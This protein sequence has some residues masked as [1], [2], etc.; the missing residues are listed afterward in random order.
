MDPDSPTK[1]Q[2]SAF[3][4]IVKSAQKEAEKNTSKEIVIVEET[5]KTTFDEREEK[6][7]V[8][9]ADIDIGGKEVDDKDDVNETK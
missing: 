1:L 7:I 8:P 5:E 4:K 2:R 3:A 9:Q 6:S